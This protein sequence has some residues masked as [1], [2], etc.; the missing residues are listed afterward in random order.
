MWQRV[1]ILQ[2]TLASSNMLTKKNMGYVFAGHSNS[3]LLLLEWSIT[4]HGPPSLLISRTSYPF[5]SQ[6]KTTWTRCALSPPSLTHWKSFLIT[7]LNSETQ[8]PLL[9]T[10]FPQPQK[11]CANSKNCAPNKW[12][13]QIK[14]CKLWLILETYLLL[15]ALII[16][17]RFTRGPLSVTDPCKALNC[18][19]VVHWTFTILWLYPVLYHILN[20]LLN[21]Y[22]HCSAGAC[23][24][25]LTTGRVEG[26]N[27]GEEVG[28]QERKASVFS[29][30]ANCCF[31]ATLCETFFF[32]CL[33]ATRLLLKINV[34]CS[35]SAVGYV[36]LKYYLCQ[37]E[38]FPLL[39]KVLPCCLTASTAGIFTWW[40][41]TLKWVTER[42]WLG[43]VD[44]FSLFMQRYF[45][46][47]V[48]LQSS[49]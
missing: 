24:F 3:V 2:W 5:F 37:F 9:W 49:F 14:L 26:W 4:S 33:D 48:R 44:S 29:S 21:I 41:A 30:L 42:F 20:V 35:I 13:L 17:S 34:L 12:I 36:L 19:C 39:G 40:V 22:L 18:S 32:C 31:I 38:Y 16:H 43:F 1:W 46:L 10:N 8:L 45:N 11:I 23:C 27:M 6:N 15:P 25:A 28:S 7:I 47:Y